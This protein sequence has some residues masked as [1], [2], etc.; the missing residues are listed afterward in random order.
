ML[1]DICP[2]VLVKEIRQ[3]L[4]TKAFAMTLIGQQALM[5]ITILYYL[6]GVRAGNNIAFADGL[7]W[8]SICVPLI[9]VMPGRGF[10]GIHEERTSQTLELLFL[11]RLSGRQIVTGK[12][13]ALFAQTLL[14]VVTTLPYMVIRYF[15]G[16]INISSDLQIMAWLT[17]ASATLT[18]IAVGFSAVESKAIRLLIT[19]AAVFSIFPGFSIIASIT[20]MS[21][22]MGSPTHAGSQ[23]AMVFG[24]IAVCILLG[25]YALLFATSRIAPQAENH[26]FA[27]RIVGLLGLAAIALIATISLDWF[28]VFTFP[29]VILV[30]ADALTETPPRIWSVYAKRNGQ[31]CGLPFFLRPFLPGWP[32]GIIYLLIISTVGAIMQRSL[33]VDIDNPEVA[34][35]ALATT[36]LYPLPVILLM[37]DR[38]KIK[39]IAPPYILLQI[40]H[41]VLTTLVLTAIETRVLMDTTIAGIFPAA[42]FILAL[43]DKQWEHP[44]ILVFVLFGVS[45]AVLLIAAMRNGK[46]I[47]KPAPAVCEAPGTEY[48]N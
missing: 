1:I 19:I 34:M 14:M 43:R 44:A 32:S 28:V 9:A 13:W 3:G 31:P 33:F 47:Q 15:L 42:T 12:W 18:A 10:H 29:L 4:K 46:S 25:I 8:F 17:L 37:Q 5:V 20:M 7:F 38:M 2:P 27:K 22:R 36:L 26:A 48:G 40:M 23:V 16:G 35:L 24:I 21:G 39:N 6:L 45:L 11:T 30:G 41:I